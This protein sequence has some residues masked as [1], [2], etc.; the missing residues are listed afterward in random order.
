MTVPTTTLL[1]HRHCVPDG[2]LLDWADLARVVKPPAS[3]TVLALRE[4]WHCSQPAVSR[5]LTALHRA[6]LADIT[7]GCGKYRVWA[8]SGLEVAL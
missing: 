3:I 5:R 7:A 4:H 6:G 1:A 2:V 8:V